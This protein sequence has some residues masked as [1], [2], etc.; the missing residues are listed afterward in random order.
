MT[1]AVDPAGRIVPGVNPPRP[2]T[3][4]GEVVFAVADRADG[5]WQV[6]TGSDEHGPGCTTTVL[7]RHDGVSAGFVEIHGPPET[8]L[9]AGVL[10]RVS[11]SPRAAAVRSARDVAVVIPTAGR[12]DSAGRAVRAVLGAQDVTRVVL[13]DNAP[14][15]GQP[16]RQLQQLRDLDPRVTVVAE[17]CKGASAARNAGVDACDEPYVAF[18]DDDTV[19]HPGWA[20]ALAAGL[21]A[22]A[23]VVTGLVLPARL[24]SDSERTF[25]L[26]SGFG[27]GALPRWFGDEQHLVD[28]LFPWRLGRLGASNSMACTRETWL[29]VGGFHEGLG[30][31][32]RSRGGEDLEF[33]TR[34]LWPGHRALYTPDAVLWHFHRGTPEDL[35]TQM[36][37]W[38]SGLTAAALALAGDDARF[39]R[40]LA[41]VLPRAVGR[42]A[43]IT[44]PGL[45]AYPAALV[46]TERAGAVFGLAP[47]GRRRRRPVVTS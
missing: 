2:E 9:T 11:P 31:G 17:P 44:D 29:R 8:L 37:S 42:L 14:V 15:A 4:G 39:R 33:M 43:S 20:R 23:A 10:D 19:V 40:S 6:R 13:V 32:R 18:T 34:A 41:R 25:E 27:H 46:W 22:G 26:R 3:T 7:V 38:G 35:R 16:H 47:A 36:F 30:P 21:D 45:D 28:P 24:S 12:V 1:G 5:R